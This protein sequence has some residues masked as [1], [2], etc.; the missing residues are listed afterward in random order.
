MY[1]VHTGFEWD[2]KKEEANL[3]KHGI[4]F[5]EASTI[6]FSRYLE[7]FYDPE[8]SIHQIRFIAI[9]FSNKGR[10]LLVVHSENMDG[11]KIRII[12]AR[13]ATKNESLN[14]FGK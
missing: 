10:V 4:S 1:N 2:P 14:T 8:H 6:F 7:I 3:K 13:E 11:T 5:E 12:S 9:G